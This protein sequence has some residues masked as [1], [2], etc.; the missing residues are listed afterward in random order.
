[1]S[2]ADKDEAPADFVWGAG[3]I[4][5][6]IGRSERA[7]FHMLEKKL[8]PA[9]RVGGRWCASRRKLLEALTNNG[10]AA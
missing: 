1:M 10:D 8:L 9:K 7:V 6:V 4:A 3:A 5:K 2:I